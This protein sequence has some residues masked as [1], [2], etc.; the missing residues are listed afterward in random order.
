[1]LGL[2]HVQY[3]YLVATLELRASQAIFPH[4]EG[5]FTTFNLSKAGLAEKIYNICK[6]KNGMEGIIPRFFE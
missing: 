2:Q 5:K 3:R 4:L 6:S 1:M